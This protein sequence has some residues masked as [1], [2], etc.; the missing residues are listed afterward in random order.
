MHNDAKCL[1]LLLGYDRSTR[2]NFK[3]PLPK[4][5]SVMSILDFIRPTIALTEGLDRIFYCWIRRLATEGYAEEFESVDPSKYFLIDWRES[6]YTVFT[7]ARYVK[8]KGIQTVS[9]RSKKCFNYGIFEIE[10]RLK[11]MDNGPMLWFGFEV[12]DLF[13]GGV[14]H[15]MFDTNRRTLYGYSGRRWTISF[16]IP[17]PDRYGEER[18]SYIVAVKRGLIAHIVDGSIRGLTISSWIDGCKSHTVYGGPP[19]TLCISPAPPPPSMP[20][21]IDIDGAGDLEYVWEDIHPWLIRV[22]DGDPDTPIR[23]NLYSWGSGSIWVDRPIDRHEIST[24]I[25]GLQ[26]KVITVLSV[27]KPGWVRV[28]ALAE[29]RY[30]WC[31]YNSYR[32]KPSEVNRMELDYG[33]YTYR[34]IYEPD[35][36]PAKILYGYTIIV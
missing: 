11:P 8:P 34:L 27:D 25:P 31:T 21:L 1:N 4:I 16:Q 23:L 13:R 35:T 33:L 29:P 36:N 5:K 17:L 22:T 24:P 28:E 6:R 7:S 10:T 26:K 20:I 2:I 15:F 18:H 32:V 9:L 19:Y 12:D 14:A 30:E 3:H